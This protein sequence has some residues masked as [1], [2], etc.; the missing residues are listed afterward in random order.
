MTIYIIKIIAYITMLLDHIKY[1]YEP[2]RN[3]I[4]MY[5]GRIAFPLF[6]FL[7]TEG[8]IHTSNL[9]KYIKRL[10]IFG[11]ISQIPFMLF[12]TFV[13]NY[14]M[15]NIM[16]TLLFGLLAITLF[17]KIENKFLSIPLVIL[18]VVLGEVLKV[19]YYGYG[20]L[21]VFILYLFKNNKL[22]LS[23]TYILLVFCK[24]YFTNSLNF[25]NLFNIVFTILPLCII[26][27]YNG[28][29]GKKFKHL[30]YW[31]YP[32]HLLI[33]AIIGYIV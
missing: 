24:Y 6:A 19:D 12:R 21:M 32:V 7:I 8:Y 28:K 9:N 25:N 22:A 11:L 23:I 18:F 27:L 5:F 10:I 3:F 33:F 31:I 15:L 30:F 4:T 29:E 17:D 1:V 2:S 26:L 16:F 13:G 14:L 20:V